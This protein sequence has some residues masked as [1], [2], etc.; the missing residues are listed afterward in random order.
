M[1]DVLKV[2]SIWCYSS[3]Q[4]S[5][6]V[7]LLKILSKKKII[8]S[9]P[10]DADILFLGPY[11]LFKFDSRFFNYIKRKIKNKFFYKIIS[12]YEKGIS[13]RKTKPLTVYYSQENLRY[14]NID[15]DFYITHDLGSSKSNH[16]RMP[17]WKEYI[18]WSHLGI[19][20]E[21][22]KNHHS[23]RYGMYYSINKLTEPLGKEF[24]NKKRDVCFITSN[25]FEPKRSIYEIIK[26]SFNIDGYGAAFNKSIKNHSLSNFVKH[27]ILKNYAFNLCPNNSIYPGYYED[28][29]VDAFHSNTLA[30]TWVDSHVNFDFNTK[31]FVNLYDH[32]K[33]NYVEICNL[34]KD[35]LF[36]KKFVNE[37][38][39]YK[40]PDLDKEINFINNI[41]SRL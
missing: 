5:I 1:K 35:D 2:S 7:N 8:F 38:L 30:L 10:N 14:D 19:K 33:D 11:N 29:I 28:R 40:S 23:S 27:D 9:S 41:L 13:F 17:A 31:S 36:L 15:A 32:I 34:L 25:L 22:L 20:R 39:L 6:L 24:L 37:P 16:F 4:D 21:I 26:K 18:D 12:D 3:V